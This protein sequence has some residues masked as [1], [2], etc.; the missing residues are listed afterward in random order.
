MVEITD[1]MERQ[2]IAIIK[3]SVIIYMYPFDV[4]VAKTKCKVMTRSGKVV[5]QVEIARNYVAGGRIVTGVVDGTRMVWDENGKFR[6][7]YSQDENDLFIPERYFDPEWKRHI[8]LSN[9]EWASKFERKHPYT[10]KPQINQGDF[11]IYNDI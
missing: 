7:V 8:K 6:D 4:N 2:C 10:K 1:E 9:S 5:K 11:E 3:R